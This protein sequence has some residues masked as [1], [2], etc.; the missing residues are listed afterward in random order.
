MFFHG[1]IV[2]LLV[3]FVSCYKTVTELENENKGDL[4][5]LFKSGKRLMS[6]FS[7]RDK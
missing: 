6:F 7:P 3:L 2:N 5:M 1:G 4:R